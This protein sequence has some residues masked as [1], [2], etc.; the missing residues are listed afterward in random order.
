MTDI[1]KE[2]SARFSSRAR[3]LLHQIYDPAEVD[4]LVQRLV[5]SLDGLSN[6]GSSNEGPFDQATAMLISYADSIRCAGQ[7]PIRTLDEWLQRRVGDCFTHL[8]LLPFYPSSSDAGFSVKDYREVDPPLGDWSDVERLAGRYKLCFDLVLNHASAQGN[9]FERFER[10]MEPERDFFLCPE[11]GFDTR[12]VTRP[13][14]SP[15]LTDF[16]IDGSTRRLWTTFGPDQV[17]L[18]YRNPELLAEM[19]DIVVEYLR[20]GAHMLRLDAVAFLWKES[21]TTCLH[22]PQTHAVVKLI[23]ALVDAASPGSLILTETNVP[24]EENVSYFGDGDEAHLVYQFSLAPLLLHA[25]ETGSTTYLCKWASSCADPPEG[26][27]F[28]NFTAS[29]DGIALRP[30]EGLIP[31]RWVRRLLD[32]MRSRGYHVSDRMVAEGRTEAYELNCSYFDACRGFS[33]DA[34]EHE[35]RF[36]L[37]QA[38]AL[39]LKGVP[40]VYIHSLI[41]TG[42]V[43]AEV[44]KTGQ[45]RAINRSNWDQ[46]ELDASLDDRSSR[47][48]RVFEAYARLLRQRSQRPELHPDVPQRVSEAQGRV[49]IVHRPAASSQLLGVFNFTGTTAWLEPDDLPRPLEGDWEI[50]AHNGVQRAAD[51][52]LMLTPYAFCWLVS[53]SSSGAV[54]RTSRESHRLSSFTASIS[55]APIPG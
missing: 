15:L 23:R 17:D 49:L 54:P 32:R 34:V 11:P 53:R 10:G 39:T 40:A 37:T 20:R 26:C 48:R 52:R 9:W 6:R 50:E 38:V 43:P 8:H 46:L 21:G 29:H 1:T 28:L 4:P 5:T 12:H 2:R 14:Q 42:N 24:H 47:H 41:A 25:I 31:K 22:R 7:S 16:D 44:E 30:L 19:M 3:S 51:E 55:E 18:D 13:R 36:L 45:A 33:T 27:T 35:R